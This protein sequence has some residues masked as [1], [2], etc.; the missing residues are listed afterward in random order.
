VPAERL[1]HDLRAAVAAP[2]VLDD[3][4]RVRVDVSVGIHVT[5]RAAEP[6]GATPDGVAGAVDHVAQH[7]AQAVVDEML[8]TADTAMYQAKQSGGG[9]QVV[10]AAPPADARLT[11]PGATLG[12][13]DG[14]R[15]SR[16]RHRRD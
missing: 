7:G 13:P 16:P 6:R 4:T 1:G 15:V 9:V 12:L 14:A 2:I 5:D 8:H 3:E 10:T 11:L